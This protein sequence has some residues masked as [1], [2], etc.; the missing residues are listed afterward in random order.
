M[1]PEIYELNPE[2]SETDRKTVSKLVLVIADWLL[3]HGTEPL[4]IE[5][6]KVEYSEHGREYFRAKEESRKKRIAE[7]IVREKPPA[8]TETPPT[9]KTHAVGIRR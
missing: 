2:N 5:K 1:N 8:P 4:D 9:T 3:Y 6:A 7:A